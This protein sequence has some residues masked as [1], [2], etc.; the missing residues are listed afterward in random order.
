MQEEEKKG[1]KP[2]EK[3]IVMPEGTGKSITCKHFPIS[4]EESFVQ[5]T[6]RLSEADYNKLIMGDGE[7]MIVEPGKNKILLQC[8]DVSGSMS[9]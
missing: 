7:A 9:G 5:Y 4:E 3:M 1:D 6:M 2:E 8:L